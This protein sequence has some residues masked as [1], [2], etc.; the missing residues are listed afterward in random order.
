MFHIINKK[1]E[2]I[3]TKE[4]IT[5]ELETAQPAGTEI[6]LKL[7]VEQQIYIHEYSKKHNISL[8]KAFQ[9]IFNDMFNVMKNMKNARET[10]EILDI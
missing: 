7:S 8:N 9:K 2:I 10:F 1:K 4:I 5:D 3:V 6:Q